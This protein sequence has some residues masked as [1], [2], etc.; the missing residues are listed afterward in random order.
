[1]AQSRENRLLTMMPSGDFA[2]LRPHL[3]RVNLD[4]RMPLSEAHRPVTHL[5]FPVEG[6]ASLVN[7]MADGSSAEVGT[8]GNEGLVGIPAILGDT[9]GPLN[10]YVQVPGYG[11]KV[12]AEIIRDLLGTSTASRTL[13]L[14]YA[15]AFFNQ[16]AQS[17]ACNTCHDI[18][19]RCCRWL[20]MTHDRMQAD[21][22]LLTQE[23]LAMML[24]VRRTGVTDV[25]RKLKGKNLINYVRGQVS[26]LDRAG[27]EQ[28]SCE[29]YNVSKVE[30]DRL[31]GP[32]R[33]LSAGAPALRDAPADGSP[34]G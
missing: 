19:Q 21:N 4:Y 13:M 25:A 33:G 34:S 16:V 3:H 24:G 5:Y 10:V 22:F 2:R 1:M 32:S 28:L 17:A 8:I 26:I 11:F 31:L 23:F 29:C 12:Q 30:F 14:H 6:V 9:V 7:T 27:L 18:E 20:L 15:H